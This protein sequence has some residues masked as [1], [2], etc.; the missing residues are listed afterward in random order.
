MISTKAHTI[1]GLIVGVVL[2]FAPYIFG[3]N[4][5]DIAALIPRIVGIFIIINELITTSPYSPLKLVSMRT[6]IVIDYAAGV[7]LGLSPWIFSFVDSP[8]NHWVPHVVVGV[9]VI[10]YALMTDTVESH[11]RTTVAR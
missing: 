6:H 10:G 9:I 3:F 2:F 1:I 8:A 4:D 7:F 11:A 5:N